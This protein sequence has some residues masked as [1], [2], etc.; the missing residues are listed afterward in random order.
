MGGAVQ[1][2]P[3]APLRAQGFGSRDSATRN[4]RAPA[5]RPISVNSA[6]ASRA[7]CS[8]RGAGVG[9]AGS[10]AGDG[11]VSR[12]ALAAACVRAR[13][14]SA[15]CVRAAAGLARSGLSAASAVARAGVLD[16]VTGLGPAA[17]LAGAGAG[18]VASPGWREPP[19]CRCDGAGA[20]SAAT[21][22]PRVEVSRSSPQ[23]SQA[24]GVGGLRARAAR[25]PDAENR[26]SPLKRPGQLVV[27]IGLRDWA[28]GARSTAVETVAMARS[29]GA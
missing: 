22:S 29:G 12:F 19:A 2:E 18:A 4:V 6:V 10:R 20:C 11:G 23:S 17:G 27:Y 28:M 3:G 1:R 7:V 16:L 26:Q 14:R 24:T 9:G 21:R 13:E 15:A 5:R 25:Y 8:T